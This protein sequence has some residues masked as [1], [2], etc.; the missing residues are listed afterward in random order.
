[1]SSNRR[2][3][4]A[5]AL[6]LIAAPLVRAG[7]EPQTDV[8]VER[9]I[10]FSSGVGFFEHRGKVDG[11]TKTELRFKTEQIND[12]LK[13]LVLQD[14]DGGKIGSVVYPSQDPLSRHCGFSGGHRPIRRWADCLI[15]ARRD[16]RFSVE[17]DFAI[18]HDPGSGKSQNRRRRNHRNVDVTSSKAG[19]SARWT[20]PTSRIELRTR[21]FRRSWPRPCSSSPNRRD[22]DKK[23]VTIEFTGDGNRR[24]RLGYV[25]ETPIWKTTYRLMMPDAG[26][27]DAKGS[28]QGWAVVENQTE[29]DWN[30]VELSLVSGRPI[31]FVQDLYQPLYIHRPV[32]KPELYASLSPQTYEGGTG[33]GDSVVAAVKRTVFKSEIT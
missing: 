22:Q 27:K 2:P 26:T 15:G 17:R 5:T 7:T 18:R 32:V 1:M 21:N 12:I 31:S 29:S 3:T 28:L 24:V 9:V 19:R 6:L 14:L 13:S 23:P 25:V 10:L 30:N 11:N 16:H 33:T 20:L 8:P 4:I